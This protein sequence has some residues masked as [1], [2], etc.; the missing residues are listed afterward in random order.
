MTGVRRIFWRLSLLCR[1]GPLI[2]INGVVCHLRKHHIDLGR[3]GVEQPTGAPKGA[4]E[5]DKP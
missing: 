5:K 1:S 2:Q 3:R 4:I